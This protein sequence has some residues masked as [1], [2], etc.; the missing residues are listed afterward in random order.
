MRYFYWPLAAFNCSVLLWAG[1]ALHLIPN[2]FGR[3]LIAG[4]FV[5]AICM[6][7]GQYAKFFYVTLIVFAFVSHSLWATIGFFLSPFVIGGMHRIIL[8]VARPDR[9]SE[10]VK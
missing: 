4:S 6:V 8:L 7:F 9:K 2:W 5:F 1:I 10:S 3:G